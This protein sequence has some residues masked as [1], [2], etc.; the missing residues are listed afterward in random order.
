MRILSP[1]N[2]LGS[3]LRYDDLTKVI[4]HRESLTTPF[5]WNSMA[6]QISVIVLF[7]CVGIGSAGLL[8]R[9]AIFVDGAKGMEKFVSPTHKKSLLLLSPKLQKLFREVLSVVYA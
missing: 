2:F 9:N 5:N 7:F 4:Q 8:R 3:R 1:S 6:E